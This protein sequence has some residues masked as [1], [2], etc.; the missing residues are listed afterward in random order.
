VSA[1]L[2]ADV[3][4]VGEVLVELSAAEP[5]ETA[6]DLRLGFSGD[7]LNAAAAAAAA[8]AHVALLTRVADDE[9]GHRL[10]ERIRGFGIDTAGV[11]LVPG[12]HGLYFVGA[13]PDGQREFVYARRGSAASALSPA[14]LDR[15]DPAHA[16]VTLCSGITCA[17]S[18]SAADTV[19]AAAQRA[20]EA[21][22]SF[23]YDPNFR[24]RLTTPEQAAQWLRR[25]APLARLVLPSC[26]GE[27]STLLGTTDPFTAAATVR[28]LGAAAAAVT[29]GARGIAVDDGGA[30]TWLDPVPA[31]VVVDQTGAGDAF[32]G[33]VAARLA[34]G[35][36]LVTAA[37]TASA[38]ASLSLQGQ[39]GTGFVP[40]L[41]ET[42]AHLATTSS[43]T[44]TGT[45]ATPSRPS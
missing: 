32:A 28:E 30:Q 19:L 3:L 37:R 33:T 44:S 43:G 1:R 5:L 11:Q 40:S 17:V 25:L 29:C 10:L 34:L 2:G 45:S 6:V 35:D 21:G 27:T 4:V 13:D 42:L 9:L 18:G 8:G 23:V 12:Q 7:A 38:A 20:S 41:A 36:D 14:D 24:P 39:G 22:R 15:L 16:A 31:R 26:P